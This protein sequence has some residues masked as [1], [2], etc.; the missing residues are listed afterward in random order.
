MTHESPESSPCQLGHFV[1]T[2]DSARWTWSPELFAIAGLQ[3]APDLATETFLPLLAEQDR[4]TVRDCILRLTHTAGPFCGK[5]SF[6]TPDGRERAVTC[7]GDST[8]DDDGT[9][10]V[11]EGYAVDI[12]DFVRENANDAVSASATHRAA[13]EQ[14]KG[15][16]MVTH[17]IDD[18]AAFSVLRAFSSRHNIKLKTV[19]ELLV[20]RVAAPENSELGSKAT[21]LSALRE[22]ASEAAS[23]A[24]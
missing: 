14:A 5:L 17:G 23:T 18:D 4:D 12:T 15:A 16:L 19:A 21:V 1:F 24:S 20:D 6:L 22:I 9:G 13:I 10:A 7:V 11:L 2:A 8:S 3:P